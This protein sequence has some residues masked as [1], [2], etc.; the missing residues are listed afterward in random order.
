MK[1]SDFMVFDAIVPDMES[2]SRDDAIRELVSSL[3]KAGQLKSTKV[4]EITRQIIER[5]N[6]GSTG[7]GKGIAVPHVKHPSVK[8][9]VGTIGC[10]KAGLDFS[11]LDKSPVYSVLLLISPPKDPDRHLQAMENIFS[12]LQKDMFRKFLRQAES[13]ETIIELM[14]EA[15]EARQDSHL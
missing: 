5:E 11:S 8:K 14:E 9:I 6:Q 15:D 7:I 4:N 10:S 1:L 13:R 2:Q 3:S 12:H